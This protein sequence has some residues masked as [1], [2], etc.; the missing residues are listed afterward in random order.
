MRTLRV[1]LGPRSYPIMVGEGL[2][3]R[4]GEILSR[5]GLSG[6]PVVVSNAKVLRLHGASLLRSLERSFGPVPVIQIGDGE[7]FKSHA[8]LMRI[9]DGLF[10]AGADRHSWLLAFGGGVIGDITGFAA[11]TFMR[12]IRYASVP[13]TLLAQ[14]D[15][16]VGGKVG[17]NVR[18]GKN[19]IGAFH[20]PSIVLS[21][22]GTLST[23][24]RRDLASGLYEVVKCGA[25]RSRSLLRYIERHLQ[26]I[27]QC[28]PGELRHIVLEA[29][30]IKVEVVSDDE[31]EEGLRIILNFGHT[32]GHALEAATRYTKFKHGE[33]VA[34][35]MIA[36]LGFGSELGMLQANES[37]SVVR[38]I[39]SVEK[40]PSLR[41]ISAEKVWN[42]LMR[43]KKFRAGSIRM[44]LLPRLGE[45]QVGSGVDP[46]RLRSYLDKFLA[47]GSRRNRN[48]ESLDGI[49]QGSCECL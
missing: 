14:V 35:G 41:G 46:A 47:C 2:L 37:K 44:V 7:Q 1:D 21:D 33:A 4:A 45:A 5:N 3:A 40:L 18:Q 31:R 17:L 15:S 32:V 26:R 8:T 25:I 27:L 24:P 48:R 36:A 30:R 42:A 28:C 49:V 38:L 43:D 23:L 12:G 22:V 10:G 11:A 19:M 29:C 34:W 6:P 39:L 16:S 9:Y 20:Q 13:T